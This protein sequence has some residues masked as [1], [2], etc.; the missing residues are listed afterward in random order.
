MEC[1]SDP[2]KFLFSALTVVDYGIVDEVDFKMFS[3]IFHGIF[4]QG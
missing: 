2:A 3:R 1:L 4:C